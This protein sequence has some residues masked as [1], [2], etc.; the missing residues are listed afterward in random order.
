MDKEA[1]LSE[2]QKSA[3][4]LCPKN[5]EKVLET[6]KTMVSAIEKEEEYKQQQRPQFS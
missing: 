2:I 1:Q 3:S 4:S 6:V 5:L